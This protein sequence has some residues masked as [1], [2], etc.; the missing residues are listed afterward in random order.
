MISST[1]TNVIAF[2]KTETI[3]DDIILDFYFSEPILEN[4]D[5]DEVTLTSVIVEDLPNTHDLGNPILPVKPVRI[6]LPENTELNNIIVT[7]SD[8]ITLG[9]G[10]NIAAGG[11]VIPIS[12]MLEDRIKP[13]IST[14]NF[15]SLY[16]FV[17][18]YSYR[19]F[20]I[21]H[22]NLHPVQYDAS[23]GELSYYKS[24]KLVIETNE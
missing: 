2:Q 20:S 12:D 8:K 19:G 13:E 21:L 16:S 5:N 3:Y 15:N 11:Y 1:I 24:M 17:G 9:S 4:I 6:L 18:V 10:F 22:L 23:N 7:P 14:K